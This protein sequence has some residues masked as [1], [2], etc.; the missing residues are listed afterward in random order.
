MNKLLIISYFILFLVPSTISYCQFND[1]LLINKVIAHEMRDSTFVFGQWTINGDSEKEIRYL[2]KVNSK[3]GIIKVVTYLNYWGI[4]KHLTCN[5]V[6]YDDRNRYIANYNIFSSDLPEMNDLGELI[7]INKECGQSKK[8]IIDLRNGIPNQIFISCDD[9][10]GD[11][12][13]LQK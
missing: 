3:F 8:T 10:Y 7:F 5:I 11:L 4:S 2:G 1:T 6:F 9:V 12:I 13:N